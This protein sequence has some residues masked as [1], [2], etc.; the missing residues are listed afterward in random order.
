[1]T[2]IAHTL[3]SDPVAARHQRA[4]LVLQACLWLIREHCGDQ[5]PYGKELIT[6]TCLF[7]LPVLTLNSISVITQQIL[8]ETFSE[9][10]D[11]VQLIASVATHCPGATAAE[12]K[13][14]FQGCYPSSSCHTALATEPICLLLFHTV[15]ASQGFWL[16]ER[17]LH[18][19]PKLTVPSPSEPYPPEREPRGF[20][21][22]WMKLYYRK[23]CVG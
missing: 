15:G 4:A 5:R 9:S 21:P 20:S 16:L 1:M 6:R 14:F 22:A 19:T 3:T 12:A 18:H 2:G 17:R 7:A 11:G 23:E 13:R 8:P 10:A